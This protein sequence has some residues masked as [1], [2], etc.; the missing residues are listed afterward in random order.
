MRVCLHDL[1]TYRTSGYECLRGGGIVRVLLEPL[2]LFGLIIRSSRMESSDGWRVMEAHADLLVLGCIYTYCYYCCIVMLL[3]GV[4]NL[5]GR[6]F[7][8]LCSA[9]P[10]NSLVGP[11]LSSNILFRTNA[12]CQRSHV[13]CDPTA[14]QHRPIFSHGSP[15]T[16]DVARH[17]CHSY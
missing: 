6:S 16:K 14:C 3:A 10:S 2:C 13:A 9:K 12:G 11:S 5:V 8:W 15:V 7:T 17:V 1:Q 4:T